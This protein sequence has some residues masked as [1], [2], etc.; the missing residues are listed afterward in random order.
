LAEFGIGNA[1]PITAVEAIKRRLVFEYVSGKIP[2]AD[3]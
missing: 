3:E 1:R 2:A